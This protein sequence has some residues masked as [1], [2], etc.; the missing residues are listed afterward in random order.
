MN[1]P[2][3]YQEAERLAALASDIWA[4]DEGGYDDEA[5]PAT[6]ELETRQ[7][8][9]SAACRDARIILAEAQVHATLALVAATARQDFRDCGTVTPDHGA[10]EEV[11]GLPR[12]TNSL[13]PSVATLAEAVAAA[14]GVSA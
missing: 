13:A 11:C 4:S 5:A 10:W 7:A 8:I 9:H 6:D 2:G 12:T 3:H 14:D 1:G